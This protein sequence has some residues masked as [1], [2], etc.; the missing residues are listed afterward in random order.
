[1]IKNSLKKNQAGY[2]LTELLVVILVFGIM[3]AFAVVVLNTARRDTRDMKRVA[4]VT[5]IRMALELYYHNCNEY[6]T[7]LVPGASLDAV[8]C[9]GLIFLKKVPYDPSGASY[10]YTPCIGSGDYHCAPGQE[11]A[12]WYEIGYNLEGQAS[13]LRSGGHLASPLGM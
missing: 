9:N 3:S 5:T 8:E 2:T 10:K 6:P 13:G 12:T 11:D 1:M 7:V 4:D